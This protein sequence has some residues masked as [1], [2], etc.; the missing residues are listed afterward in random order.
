MAT[1]KPQSMPVRLEA[2]AKL[3]PAGH[4]SSA[5]NVIQ[6]VIPAPHI[7]TFPVTEGIFGVGRLATRLKTLEGANQIGSW[8]VGHWIDHTHTAIR[9]RFDNGEDAQIATLS[10]LV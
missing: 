10:L 2:R 4:R 9:I 5:Q 3:F 6:M 8:H 1:A 7:V